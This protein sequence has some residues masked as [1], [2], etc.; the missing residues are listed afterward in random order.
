MSMAG[1][2]YQAYQTKPT[3]PNLS[4]Q[5]YQTKPTKTNL[6]NQTHETK[7]TKPKLPNQTYQ[8]KT[9]RPTYKTKPTKP[10]LPNLTY[11]TKISKFQSCPELGT[12]QPQ[13]VL[14]RSIFFPNPTRPGTIVSPIFFVS[15][16]C[17]Y[18]KLVSQDA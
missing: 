9:T 10:N 18:S 12:A 17:G 14:S 5:I 1:K 13:L 4:N 8:T 7:P 3:K 11:K 2:I 15:M 6:T 16:P